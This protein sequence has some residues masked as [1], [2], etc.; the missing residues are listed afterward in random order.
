MRTIP[1]IQTIAIHSVSD[2]YASSAKQRRGAL[3]TA[4]IVAAAPAFT[5]YAVD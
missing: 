2:A 3:S 1:L 4:I 5:F